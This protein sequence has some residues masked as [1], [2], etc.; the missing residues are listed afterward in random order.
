MRGSYD[1]GVLRSQIFLCSNKTINP[2]KIRISLSYLAATT[3][4]Q[5]AD[6]LT[7][8]FR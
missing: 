4:I 2:T 5:I 8:M 7:V 6:G 1:A 3:G